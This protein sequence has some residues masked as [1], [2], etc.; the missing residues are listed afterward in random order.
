MSATEEKAE[1]EKQV[2]KWVKKMEEAEAAGDMDAYNK[3]V[4]RIQYWERE[5][6]LAGWE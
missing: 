4:E 2:R 5:A 3:A 6:E 1:A